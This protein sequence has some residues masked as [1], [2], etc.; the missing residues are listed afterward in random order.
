[1]LPTS[2][3]EKEFVYGNN[4]VF[5]EHDMTG[6]VHS[7]NMALNQNS[8][9]LYD[10]NFDYY[11]TMIKKALGHLMPLSIDPGRVEAFKRCEKDYR[12]DAAGGMIK[13][14]MNPDT[15]VLRPKY[16]NQMVDNV[17]ITL[18]RASKGSVSKEEIK[19]YISADI[20]DRVKRQMVRSDLPHNA[21]IKKMVRLGAPTMVPFTNKYISSYPYDFITSWVEIKKNMIKEANQVIAS[22]ESAKDTFLTYVSALNGL[23][24]EV[25]WSSV[26]TE[27]LYYISFN[28]SRNLLEAVSYLAFMTIRKIGMVANNIVRSN[29][30]LDR[31]N[32]VTMVNSMTEGVLDGLM[33]KS[34]SKSVGVKLCNG[35]TD[36]FDEISHKIYEY[37]RGIYESSPFDPQMGL[38]GQLLTNLDVRLDQIE[39]DN[40]PYQKILDMYGI[41]QQGL[42]II[43]SNCDDYMIVMDDVIKKSG[44]TRELQDRFSGTVDAID[45]ITEYTS[46]VNISAGADPEMHV[47]YRMMRE[48][49]DYSDNMA[50]IAEMVSDAKST[51]NQ[52]I[53]RFDRNINTEYKNTLTISEAKNFLSSLNDQF[54]TL[55]YSVAGKFMMRLKNIAVCL[56]KFDQS[57]SRKLEDMGMT[58]E[59]TLFENSVFSTA[60]EAQEEITDLL[61]E[62]FIERYQLARSKEET[63]LT[64]LVQESKVSD[65]ATKIKAVLIRWFEKVS[66]KLKGLINSSKAESDTDFIKNNKSALLE[67]S[68]SNASSK[69]PIIEYEKLQPAENMTKDLK[70]VIKNTS[71]MNLK[72]DKLLSVTD[73][74]SAANIL[75]GSRIPANVWEDGD[76]SRN[77]AK[78]YK[79]G[80][81]PE[82]P[83]TLKNGEY[84]KAVEAAIEYCEDF[85]S[86]FL[87]GVEDSIVLVKDNFAN[88]IEGLLT[89]AGVERMLGNL[90]MEADDDNNTNDNNS[91]GNSQG[92]YKPMDSGSSSSSGKTDADTNTNSQS[93]SSSDSS[94]SSSTDNSNTSSTQSTDSSS[95]QTSTDSSSSSTDSSSSTSSDNASSSSSSS[96]AGSGTDSEK[97]KTI[98]ETAK[99]VEML[100][101]MIQK[102]CNGVLTAAFDRYKDYMNLLRE[103]A[104]E[105]TTA[106]TSSTDKEDEDNSGENNEGSGENNETDNGGEA[107]TDNN[108]ASN[109]DTSSDNSSENNG[110]DNN[111]GNE[112]NGENTENN[113][114]QKPEEGNDADVAAV[115]QTGL[116]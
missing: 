75:F 33:V 66:A 50:G 32:E 14:L 110:T 42:G 16:L 104:G 114:E 79:C 26:D 113:E 13:E 12:I 109:T 1:M 86:K 57:K 61:F 78:Y 67:K 52:L 15:I 80:D 65:I 46:A 64:V 88:N 98:A 60:Y 20:T 72:S 23:K 91:D 87:P 84:K 38:D 76:A 54:E 7:A 48:V 58:A 90:F 5:R 112:N 105:A 83:V 27:N 44:F 68:Y 22:I 39:Y 63:G 71:S 25:K 103:A 10:F 31:I 56:E 19:R 99:K 4:Q 30:I 3:L 101:R 36:S 106:P 94:S 89:E 2:Y 6:F 55:T 53:D 59:K 102:F 8:D 24:A 115:D 17:G 97:A 21:P 81:Y 11:I 37:H 69:S 34:D 100:Q 29:M 92:S 85:Y 93:D 95:N 82:N 18:D 116:F 47:Y 9:L 108:D 28:A 96:D 111:A 35:E 49:R 107:P 74:A 43:S 40:T 41:I 51:L 45:D 77:I 73:E 70:F 62:A